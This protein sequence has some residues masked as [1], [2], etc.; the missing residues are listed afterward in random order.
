MAEFNLVSSYE[1]RGDQPQAIEE[2]T[3]GLDRG[4]KHQTLLGVTGSGKTFSMAHVIKN[5]GRPT[6]VIS[7]NKTLA[8]QLYGELRSFFPE[9]AVEYFI[10]YYDYYQ[11]EAYLPVTDTFIEK[12]SSVNEEI[13]KLRLKATSSLM[14]RDDVIVVASVSCIY[15]IGSPK[16]YR[17]L[18]VLLKK[19]QEY[20]RKALFYKFVDIHYARNDFSFEPGTFRVRGDS[21][22]IYPAYAENPIRLEF[23]GDTLEDISII[24]PMTGEI[25]ESRD[26]AV[27][28]P[29]KHFVTTE[30]NMKRAVK[31]IREELEERLI[32][33]R[34]NNKLLEA[35][36]L[37]QRTNFDI[38]MMQELGYCSGIENY[39]RHIANREP[40]ER[41]Y[42]LIDFFPDDFLTIIDESHVTIPQIRGMYNGDRARKET[43]VEHGFRLPSALDNRPMQF[44]EFEET[45]EKRVY[46]S[47]T[48]GPYEL[49]QCD[50]VVV[51]QVIRP[52]GLM[53][54]EVDVRPTKGQIDDL[55]EE[56]TNRT[57]DGAR[58]L[59]TTL[60]KRM[61]EDLT[62]YLRNMN[63]RVRYL[64]SEIDSV[65]RV[66]ILR[67]LRLGEF[68][69]LVGINLLREGLDLPEVSLVAILDAD[70]EGFLRSERSLMQTAGRAARHK[71]GKVIFYAD[72]VT[73]SMQK[74]IDETERRR[75]I[76]EEYNKEHGI[77][78][79]SIIKSVDDVMG[80]TFI[81]NSRMETESS[82]VADI[83]EKYS[84]DMDDL[85]LLEM[86]R[87]EMTEA[88]E[89]RE[90]E[91]AA[92]LRDEVEKLEEELGISE[93]ES[94]F[95]REG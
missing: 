79:E 41:P 59:V 73:D 28:Y 62:D 48:P 76:Q 30:E 49:E 37:E 12:D 55:I 11:P 46:V 4:D 13:D 70:K 92:K 45:I 61:S 51:E 84:Q 1:P 15:G 71:K 81:A 80:S 75:K 26:T 57:E 9:N 31:D 83:T 35:Q 16:E 90:F 95:S 93:K 38:E 10:S 88:A 3:E 32:E 2:L 25:L 27:I 36:R 68:D 39:S 18:M 67:D 33:L 53:D 19:G 42:T 40:G 82:K 78:P 23:W 65:E 89:N 6:L 85:N 43:L 74:V 60:T 50:G 29:A 66:S 47:A 94:I 72:K 20:A 17:D 7:H 91:K 63:L 86:L 34:D 58:I 87:Q 22:E 56:I 69:V 44:E 21:V 5:Y 54:P 64:H 24:D 52:T 77:E 8:A 14:A